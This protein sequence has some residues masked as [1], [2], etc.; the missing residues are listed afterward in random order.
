VCLIPNLF[1]LVFRQCQS[2][3]LSLQMEAVDH[4][5]R[6]FD[7]QPNP[8]HWLQVACLFVIYSHQCDQRNQSE[9]HASRPTSLP[10]T[11]LTLVGSSPSGPGLL[12]GLSSYSLGL[13][14]DNSDQTFSS[15]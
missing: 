1:S 12:G 13:H 15:S 6:W 10:G 2:V 3:V 14:D 11:H 7:T 8:T 9:R 4:D 5:H